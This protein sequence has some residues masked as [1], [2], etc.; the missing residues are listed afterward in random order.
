MQPI[1]K[2]TICHKAEKAL[3]ILVKSQR[4][5]KCKKTYPNNSIIFAL[6]S[7]SMPAFPALL[8]SAQPAL[9]HELGKKLVLN[10]NSKPSH[11]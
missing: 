3:G 11:I 7:R 9:V 10:S 5:V 6:K 8:H 2:A 4:V 1:S